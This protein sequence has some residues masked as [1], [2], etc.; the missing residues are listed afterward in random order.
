[1]NQAMLQIEWEPC[2]LPRMRDPELERYMK[3]QVGTVP[4]SLPYLAA[5][6]WLARGLVDMGYDS[7]G[8]AYLDLSLADLIGLEVSRENSCRFCY[9]VSRAMLRF[10]GMSEQRVLELE[11]RLA[12]LAVDSRT[13]AAVHFA[14]RMTRS[15]PLV[16]ADD[17]RR[18]QDAGFSVDESKEIAAVV[19]YHLFGNRSATIAAIPPDTMEQ[20]P[21]RFMMRLLR[22]LI[23][24]SLAAHRKPGQRQRLDQPYDGPFADI[25]RAYGDLPYALRFA[26]LLEELWTSTLLS[27]RCKALMFAVVA[28]GLGCGP[29]GDQARALL[30]AEGLDHAAVDRALAHLSAPEL[31]PVEN[32]LLP[33]ARETLWY[34]PA[35]IQ[36]RA[37]AVSAQMSP[38]QFLEA[39]GVL[40][41]ANALCRLRAAVV[42]A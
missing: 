35:A 36:R 33:F 22:P 19:A 24:R 12:D 10:S 14:R 32:L 17:R 42:P 3:R 18:L 25:V 34:Q 29:S 7:G 1:M 20:M 23:A 40:A 9:A 41:L 31:S 39:V 6:P 21:D 26:R 13:A 37:Q 16:D 30:V 38:A 8:L 27:R 11:R 15:Q 4:P 28:K 5:C 2:P